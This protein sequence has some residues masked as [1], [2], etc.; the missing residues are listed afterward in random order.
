MAKLRSTKIQKWNLSPGKAE[1]YIGNLFM[2]ALL[3][4][5][6]LDFIVQVD[7]DN[8]LGLFLKRAPD[9]RST[10]KPKI[11]SLWF[12]KGKNLLTDSRETYDRRN[13]AEASDTRDSIW[14]CVHFIQPGT[15]LMNSVAEADLVSCQIWTW[16]FWKCNMFPS[17]LPL[18]GFGIK[19]GVGGEKVL[20]ICRRFHFYYEVTE[21]FLEQGSVK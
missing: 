1:A 4:L 18:S 20:S 2:V 21:I 8:W 11:N 17:V 13:L 12:S 15:Q 16:L 9:M 3:N 5:S 14:L 7:E 19:K 10:T 6:I